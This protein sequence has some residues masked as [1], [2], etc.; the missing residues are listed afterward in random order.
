M[1]PPLFLLYLLS[2]YHQTWHDSS[3]RQNLSKAEKVKS[4]MTSLWRLWCHLC[5]DEYR[6]L[7]KTFYI[8]V[9][10]ASSSFIWSYSNLAESFSTNTAF[11]WKSW[12]WINICF[13]CYW[14]CHQHNASFFDKYSP[15]FQLSLKNFAFLTRIMEKVCYIWNI[16]QKENSLWHW[17]DKYVDLRW[18]SLSFSWF[19]EYNIIMTS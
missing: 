13:F 18:Q 9:G 16:Y 1:C 2:S 17:I 14:W 7:L 12:I 11:D 4:I 8:R 15:I 3:L 6:K 10:A 5:Y 19:F